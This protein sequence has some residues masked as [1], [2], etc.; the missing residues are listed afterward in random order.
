MK[1]LFCIKTVSTCSGALLLASGS[2]AAIAQAAPPPAEQIP[3]VQS[4]T[5]DAPQG[6]GDIVVTA[7][8]QNESLHNVPLTV[9]AQT[10]EQLARSGITNLREINIAVPGLVFTQQGPFAQPNLRGI[11]TSVTGPGA[12]SPI[13]IYLDG[14]Y[15]T[16]QQG[17]VFDLPDVE[18]VEV[19]KGPQGTLFGRNATGGAI[20]IITRAPN[21]TKSEGSFEIDEGAF[22][23]SDAKT[24]N[25]LI[26][27]GFASTPLSDTLAVGLAGSYE[28]VPG[29]LT[30]GLT[31]GRAGHISS[32]VVRGKLRWEPAPNFRVL[33][34]AYASRRNDG[35]AVSMVPV[36]GV[37]VGS[38]YP[39]TIYD[40]R[41]WHT[42]SELKN[43]QGTSTTDSRGGSLKVEVDVGRFGTLSSLTGYTYVNGL[44]R[45]DIDG[46]YSPTCLQ[47]FAC[48]TPYVVHYGPSK[49][50]QQ[51][52][53]FSS[54]KLGRI[55]FVSGLFLYRDN[56]HIA[57]LV[58][59]TL[60][61]GVP[62]GVAPFYNHARV[63]SK[64]IA[65]YGEA[66]WDATDSLHLIG[67]IRYS[68]ENKDGVGSV[69]GGPLFNFG[70]HPH[71]DSWTPRASIRY[72]ISNK[73]NVYFTYSQGFKS[74][75]LESV[76][77]SNNVAKP[78][79]LTSYEGGFKY[80]S[81]RVGFNLSAFYY[82]YKDIQIQFYEGL[83]EVLGNAASA[84]IY[85]VDVDTSVR[86]SPDLTLRLAGS[87][88]PH[89][90]YRDFTDGVAFAFPITATGLQQIDIDASGT[91]V[92]KSPKFS[93]N[94]TVTYNHEFEAG[95]I[96]A[97]F[98]LYHSSSYRWDLLGRFKTRS[99]VTLGARAG[100]SP[101]GSRFRFG[102][103]GKNLTNRAYITATSTSAEAD[104]GVYAPPR[105]IGVSVGYKF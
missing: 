59:Q 64:A 57:S 27:K 71:W 42:T 93:G 10:G 16:N 20:S 87:W 94:A 26:A 51:E 65:G 32:F 90:N 55:S 49:T 82:D 67:G 39:D 17:N 60:V 34:T 22:V 14:I 21:L 102:I 83:A 36:G 96:D 104:E 77:L 73:A 33:A 24:S 30:N 18:R 4:P 80:T 52:F 92:L 100:Y 72:D 6:V 70:G 103:Y 86:V 3:T 85:G 41:P 68:W 48:I 44:I 63:L 45:E 62:E 76:N 84:R 15:Q 99:Y 37:T 2:A 23:G 38:Q 69:L 54:K 91:R 11:S 81:S 105:E 101:E 58:N 13:A 46:T 75:V 95:K 88:L 7:R 98:T 56:S 25:H 35:T 79:K 5:A 66:T 97:N 50:W 12:D 61:G 43:S 19:L 53:N 40:P 29:Y 8:R 28:N 31:G 89:A 9:V 47:A 1:T 78:E 74:G